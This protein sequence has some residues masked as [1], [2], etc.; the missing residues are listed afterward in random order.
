MLLVPRPH[1]TVVI[2]PLPHP[3]PYRNSPI[4]IMATGSAARMI[5]QIMHSTVVQG[6]GGEGEKEADEREV[7]GRKGGRRER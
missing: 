6:K 7:E 4:T 5:R 2:T 3:S 1:T